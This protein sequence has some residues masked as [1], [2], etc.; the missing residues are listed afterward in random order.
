VQSCL[1]QIN[2]PP[3]SGRPG[4]VRAPSFPI[5]AF[6]SPFA[7]PACTFFSFGGSATARSRW[8]CVE[9]SSPSRLFLFAHAL[10]KKILYTTNL[11]PTRK[12]NRGHIYQVSNTS[13]EGAHPIIPGWISPANRTPGICRELQKIPS[14]SQIALALLLFTLALSLS[15]SQNLHITTYPLLSFLPPRK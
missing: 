12:E 5:L 4:I 1:E 2:L 8:V 11:L 14:K 6:T 15:L 10:A 7:D 9:M 3:C 13:A